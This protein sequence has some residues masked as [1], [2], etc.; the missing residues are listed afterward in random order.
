MKITKV[1][2]QGCGANLKVDE[3][4]R[5][6]TCNYCDARLE[7]IHDETVTHTRRLEKVEEETSLLSKKMRVIELQNSI[8]HADRAWEKFRQSVSG[9]SENGQL[10][11]P[12][13]GV[14]IAVGIVGFVLGSFVIVMSFGASSPWVGVSLGIALIVITCFA[15]RHDYRKAET[16]QLQKYRYET[17]RKSL[18]QQLDQ[19]MKAKSITP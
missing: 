14:A 19:A 8:E 6:V 10:V 1:C 12:N 17:A 18:L 3:S 4:I 5:Y 9:R 11:E 13:A 2:C 7:V 15:V 16:F